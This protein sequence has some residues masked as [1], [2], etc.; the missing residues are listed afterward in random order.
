[1]HAR[2]GRI[3]NDGR[4]LQR[5]FMYPNTEEGNK[6]MIEGHTQALYDTLS[7]KGIP[8][9]ES[10]SQLR[11]VMLS[12]DSALEYS[13]NNRN[14]TKAQIALYGTKPQRLSKMIS[15]AHKNRSLDSIHH[16]V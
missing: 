16:T 4:W 8:V 14:A 7:S 1:M 2:D 5:G 12:T 15:E 13:K 11:E 10:S 6:K 3:T 9:S